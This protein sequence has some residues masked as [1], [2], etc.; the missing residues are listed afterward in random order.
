MKSE[1]VRSVC[2]CVRS[3]G[4]SVCEVMVCVR[5][6]GVRSEHVRGEGVRR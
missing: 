1:C 3:D 4:V 2:E 6:D 5:S